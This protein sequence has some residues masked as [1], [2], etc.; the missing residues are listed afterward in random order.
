ML[1]ETVDPASG[2]SA[3][4]H[5]AGRS[6]LITGA[7]RGI[8]LGLVYAFKHAGARLIIAAQREGSGTPGPADQVVALDI[9]DAAA[10][11][12]IAATYGTRIDILVNNAG[13]NASR[14]F[15][16]IGP[17]AARREMEVNYFG[18]LNM[19]R[20]FSASMKARRTGLI[21][22][23]LTVLSYVSLPTMGSYCASKSALLALTQSVRAELAPFNVGVCGV[24]PSVVDTRMGAH[25]SS[26]KL[27]V[28]E[29]SRAVIT[30]ITQG[31][32]DIFVGGSRDLLMKYLADP[33]AVER[34]MASRLN[35]QT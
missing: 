10:V 32:E 19:V 23:I 4:R 25:L 34:M 30:G 17:E 22:N 21:V 28:E 6:V 3:A 33:K 26:P 2:R 13:V 15:L 20:S 9:T 8:G 16:D 7:N 18:T 11:H 5:I 27:S 29:V 1:T 35:P 31:D 14:R 12:D 24:F